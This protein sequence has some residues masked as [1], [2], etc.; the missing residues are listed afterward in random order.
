MLIKDPEEGSGQFTLCQ[1]GILASLHSLQDRTSFIS[2]NRFF[3]SRRNANLACLNALYVDF[4]FHKEPD[5]RAGT[6]DAVQAAIAGHLLIRG[7]PE[8]SFFLQT[9]RGLAAIWMI[10]SLPPAAQTRWQA[11]MRALVDLLAPF[12]VDRAGTDPARVFRIPGTRNEKSDRVVRVSG[13]DCR[14]HDFDALADE[15]FV[16]AGRPTR[17]E[18]DARR[19]QQKERVTSGA[20]MPRGLTQ[21]ERFA[22]ILTDLEVFRDFHGGVIPMGYRNTWLHFYATCLTHQHDVT[23]IEDRIRQAADAATPG[24]GAKEVNTVIKQAAQMS[25]MP[26]TNTPREDARYSYRGATIAERL[27]ISAEQARALGLRQVMPD[28]E[29]RRRRAESQRQRRA[30]RG[31]VSREEY[32]S[33]NTAS[34]EKPWLRFGLGRSQYYARKKAGTLTE[35]TAV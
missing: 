2:L 21:C 6:A 12:G 34:K 25:R 30:S 7:V 26:A 3:G 18:L 4:D 32:L 28:E 1:D 31:S 10:Q 5:W 17:S 23:D 33:E 35:L 20:P 15:I 29:R 14:R 9:G 27:G 16:A 13:G 8:P 22:Q 19:Q 11:A 24:L